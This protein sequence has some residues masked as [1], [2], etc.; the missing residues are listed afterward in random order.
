MGDILRAGQ[1]VRLNKRLREIEV[2][3]RSE[4][5]LHRIS[6][7]FVNAEFDYVEND[8]IYITLTDGV[9]SDCQ[10][11]KNVTHASLWKDSLEWTF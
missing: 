6:G 11:T 7:G 1:V 10:N 8:K 2:Q 5:G 3:M 9:Q 4:L